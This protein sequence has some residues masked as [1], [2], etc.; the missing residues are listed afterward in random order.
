MGPFCMAGGGTGGHVIPALAVAREL[1]NRGYE[2]YFVGTQRGAESRLV[3]ADGFPL[4]LVQLG[5]LM[6]VGVMTKV[7]SLWGLMRSTWIQFRRFSAR[8]PSAVFSMGGYVAGPPVLAAVLHGIPLVVM[9]PNAVPGFTNRHIARW[10]KRAL[11]SFSETQRYFPPGRAELTGR[12]VRD[13]F[14]AIPPKPKAATLT[15]LIT[16]G[17]QGSRTLNLAARDSWARFKAAGTAVRLVH[18]TGA[19][20]FEELKPEWDRAGLEGEMSAFISDMP[21]AFAQADLIICRSGGTV[22]EIAAAGKPSVMIPFPFAADQHQLR[23]AEA[24]ERAGASRMFLDKDWN[25][26]RMFQVVTE[27][28]ADRGQLAAM[29]EAARKLARPG[30]AARA[31]DVLVE[32]GG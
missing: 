23:N 31:A 26:E 10:V 28:M 21:A 22:S 3:P 20:M 24:F 25:G 19:L 2:V 29:G 1:R 8:R 7:S 9:E 17:S 6:N 14:F 18:Q 30:A 15:V 27:L 32:V 16:G 5:G 12:P 4:E 11:V 13:E